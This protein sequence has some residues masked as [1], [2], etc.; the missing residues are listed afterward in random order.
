MT[1]V[2]LLIGCLILIVALVN[3]VN[4]STALAPSR[5]KS[6]NTQKTF[7]ATNRFLHFCIVSEAMMFALISCFLGFLWCYLLGTTSLQE[8]L[9]ASL[10]PLHHTELSFFIIGI[11]L[12][13]G[14][15]AGCYPAFYMTS[16]PPALVL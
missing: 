6:L 11:S 12:V 2:L 1:N 10:N 3:F 15:V 8:A 4:F 16:F 14:W 5:I 7:G 9:Y 13:V